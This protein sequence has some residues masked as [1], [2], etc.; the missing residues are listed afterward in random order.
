MLSSKTYNLSVVSAKTVKEEELLSWKYLGGVQDIF[1]E[2]EKG[3][4]RVEK[5][6]KFHSC[7]FLVIFLADL[8]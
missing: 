4:P 2:V 7:S 8:R 1:V 5:A 3:I 6:S